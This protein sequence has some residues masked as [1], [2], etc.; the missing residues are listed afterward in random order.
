MATCIYCG[1]PAGLLKK[2]HKTCEE[3]Y[4]KAQTDI[5]ELTKE[6]I[7]AGANFPE[8]QKKIDLLTHEG[9]LD[10][11]TAL[12]SVVKGWEA[13]VDAYLEDGLLSKDEEAQLAKFQESSG[14][15]Q[16]T[17]DINGVFTKVVKAAFLR[18]LT[19]SDEIPKK[20]KISGTIPFNLQKGEELV[21]LFNDVSYLEERTKRTY[22]GGS[23]GMSVRVVKGVYYRT[24]AFKGQPVD[25]QVTTHMD[26]GLLG[27]TQ[28]H[29][30]F[31][32]P[33]K[34]FRVKYDKIVSFT[35]FD[36]GIGIVRDVASAK[37]QM[38]ITGDG[39]FTYNLIMNMAERSKV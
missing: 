24:S 6:T 16:E 32:G 17:L 29:I 36:D 38:F 5:G 4:A 27:V 28:K 34:S 18:D 21:W 2:K 19:E 10:E 1:A 22:V 15:S 12:G 39:W 37:P 20:I 9:H 31:S 13:A 25:T 30:Y 26:D 14:L 23:Q 11:V 3:M 8:A 7:L 35:P 33:S